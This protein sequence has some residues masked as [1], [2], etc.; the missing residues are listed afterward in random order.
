VAARREDVGLVERLRQ[1]H[2][3]RVVWLAEFLEALS[4]GK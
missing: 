2:N 3:I 1:E 4:S